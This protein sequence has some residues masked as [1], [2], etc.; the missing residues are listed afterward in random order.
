MGASVRAVALVTSVYLAGKL[1]R[2]D[3]LYGSLGIATVFL[4]WLFI[5]SRI[6]VAATFLNASRWFAR[7]PAAPAAA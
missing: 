2:V 5:A 1:A 3:D 4:A 6:I 7:H